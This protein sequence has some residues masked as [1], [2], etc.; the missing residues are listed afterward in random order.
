MQAVSRINPPALPDS[1]Q[2]G[3]SQISIAEPGR[4]A[5][6][7]GQV[8]WKPNGEA[9][10]EDLTL[11]AQLVAKNAK[12]AL[13]AIGASPQDIVIARIFMCDLTPETMNEAVPALLEMFD[14]AQPCITGVGVAALA[15]PDLKIEMELTVRL[16]D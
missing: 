12:A 9:V 16:P 6:I 5:Y 1:T 3:Y 11:Q 4:M 10:P 13:D 8:A 15:A 14:G 2:M 7:S